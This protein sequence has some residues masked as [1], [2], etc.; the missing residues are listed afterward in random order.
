MLT[1]LIGLTLAAALL[2]VAAWARTRE[3]LD[4]HNAQAEGRTVTV[5][6]TAARRI[7]DRLAPDALMINTFPRTRLADELYDDRPPAVLDRMATPP[8]RRR[9]QHRCPARPCLQ[10]SRQAGDGQQ[11]AQ[12]AARS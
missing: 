12:P 8:T 7:I 11:R 3:R 2:T 9:P 10:R 4:V 1:A 5:A 6:E